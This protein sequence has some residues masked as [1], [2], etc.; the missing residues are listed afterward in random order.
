MK[1]AVPVHKFVE[2]KLN[3][4]CPGVMLWGDKG[5]YL[6]LEVEYPELAIPLLRQLREQLDALISSL[7]PQEA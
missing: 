3:A 1:I 4:F 2:V 6:S 5:E 7:E